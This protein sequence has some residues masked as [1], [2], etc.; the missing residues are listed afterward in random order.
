MLIFHR[1][2]PQTLANECSV[3]GVLERPYQNQLPLKA[4]ELT[5][6]AKQQN[7]TEIDNNMRGAQQAI[8]ENS[9]HTK[10]AL[11]RI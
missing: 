6:W 4:K 11:V 3:A 10:H 2:E 7:A 1:Q 9:S 5:L 8:D